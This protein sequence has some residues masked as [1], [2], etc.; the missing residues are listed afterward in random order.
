MPHFG[1]RPGAACRTS[2]CIGQ[3]YIYILLHFFTC[4]AALFNFDDEIRRYDRALVLELQED[5]VSARFGKQG[6]EVDGRTSGVHFHSFVH[7]VGHIR[8]HAR[9]AMPFRVR[10]DK[11]ERIFS[12]NNGVTECAEILL[13][14]LYRLP[15][16]FDRK[17]E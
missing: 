6:F 16:F 11:I 12:Q 15:V 2:G 13:K 17:R 14:I 3:V 5:F 10:V 1:H 4:D 8:A 7:R 9:H